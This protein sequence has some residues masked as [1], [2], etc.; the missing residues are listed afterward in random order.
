MIPER[1]LEAASLKLR[2]L[3]MAAVIMLAALGGG[4]AFLVHNARDA[5][6]SEVHSSMHLARTLLTTTMAMR[7]EAGNPTSPPLPGPSATCVTC[8]W[9]RR[10]ATAPPVRPRQSPAVATC[11]AGSSA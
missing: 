9:S 5:I 1:L 8:G 10:R 4:A 3:L 11:R 7:R 2:I 6:A